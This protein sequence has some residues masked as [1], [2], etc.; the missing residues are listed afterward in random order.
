M[1]LLNQLER[2]VSEYLTDEEGEKTKSDVARHELDIII[3]DLKSGRI[4]LKRA[5]VSQLLP[6]DSEL[7]RIEREALALFVMGYNG[8]QT[9]VVLDRSQ[10]Y[11]YNMRHR[12]RI[13]LGLE[14]EQGFDAW[15]EEQKAAKA[16]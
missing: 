12:V 15:F 14:K 13:K 11:I 4:D 7:N 5:E 10:R 9:A 16:L 8:K 1:G 6:G 2:I 3:Q